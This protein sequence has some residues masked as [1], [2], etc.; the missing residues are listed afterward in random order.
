MG[1]RLTKI[2]TG[3]GDK[4]TTALASGLRVE[5]NSPR[6]LAIG[7]VD[8]LNSCIGLVLAIGTPPRVRECLL[9]VQYRLFDAGAQLGSPG[10]R[11]ITE[12][13]VL[14]IEREVDRFNEQLG[15]PKEFGLPGGSHAAAACRVARAVCRRAESQ[16]VSLNEV[17]PDEDGV[18]LVFLN[19]LSDLLFAVA[20]VLAAAASSPE[21]P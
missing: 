10:R 3:T 1:N 8:E 19:R 12:D 15:P 16:L 5:K 9:E 18:L 11:C 2:T 21:S 6:I 14:E 7:V 20:G 4:G 13:H 17:D